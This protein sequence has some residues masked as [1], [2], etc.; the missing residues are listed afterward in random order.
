MEFSFK[1]KSVLVTGGAG[2]IGFETARMFA[3]QEQT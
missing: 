2:G 1:G 3:N